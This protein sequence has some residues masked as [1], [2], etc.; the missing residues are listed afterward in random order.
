MKRQHL[1]GTAM[2]SV[3]SSHNADNMS[4]KSGFSNGFSFKG[5]GVQ[6]E[7]PHHPYPFSR[8][9]VP[10]VCFRSLFGK[11]PN[12][13]GA[14]FFGMVRS[15]THIKRLPYHDA[16]CQGLE[17]PFA[18]NLQN[19]RRPEEKQGPSR[20]IRWDTLDRWIYHLAAACNRILE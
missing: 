4:R 19:A 17:W 2:N 15:L 5:P 7:L 6:R 20:W 13:E 14:I 3:F 12:A 10:Q 1:S 16:G 8:S 9:C 11:L 18:L